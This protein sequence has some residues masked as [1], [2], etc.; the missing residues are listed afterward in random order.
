[1]LAEPTV[2][3]VIGTTN[4]ARRV[5]A[6]LTERGHAVRH[7]AEPDDRD[8]R[9][10]VR[11]DVAGVAIVTHGDRI[12]LRYAF[13][14]AH[15]Q[16]SV[17]IL[18]TIF[19][20]T[21]AE[22]VRALLPQCVVASPG[23]LLAPSLVASCLDPEALAMNGTRQG[24]RVV[25]RLADGLGW[26]RWKSAPTTVWRARLG[27]LR[28]QLRPHDGDARML[29]TGLGG[30]VAVLLT[31]WVWIAGTSGEA[32]SAALFTAA[33]I[34]AGVGPADAHPADPAYSIVSAIGMLATIAFTALLTAGII[35]RIVGPRLSGV[36]GHRAI[37]RSGHVIV[38][39]LGQVGLRVCEY[40][41]RHKVP[42]IGVERER[43]APNLR[44]AQS[45]RIPIVLAH[46]EDRRVL[47]RLRLPHA[48]A[49]VAVGS[50]DLDNVEIGVAAHAV[51]PHTRIILRAGEH[52]AIAE[53]RSL[54]PLG[55]TRDVTRASAAYA[56]AVLLEAKP[57]S[58]VGDQQHDY[59]ELSDE[60]FVEWPVP[61]PDRCPHS[62]GGHGTSPW[63][64][65]SQDTGSSKWPGVDGYACPLPCSLKSG[66]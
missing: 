22:E 58:V 51:A 56:I 44:L 28:G 43:S 14:V 34:V 30:I 4:L 52:E 48:R 29:L 13:A 39:G 61:S 46:G 32:A 40:L 26:V 16:P 42:V 18:V 65:P 5:C 59:I 15:I 19:D 36:V 35:D 17:R 8:L 24:A 31:E 1:M 33:R 55:T 7:L 20:R 49:L 38:I 6:G 3:V 2:F 37:P 54:L 66:L 25:R 23:D 62:A 63:S 50:D 11:H 64:Y 41:R 27:R 47:E 60:T 53:T 45:L 57:V 10:A 12:A 9:D 21:T